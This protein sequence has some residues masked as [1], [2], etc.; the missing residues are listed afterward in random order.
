[1]KFCFLYA[2]VPTCLLLFYVKTTT[3][4]LRNRMN[5]K[6]ILVRCQAETN[7]VSR[8]LGQALCI[9]GWPCVR[10]CREIRGASGDCTQLVIAMATKG[11]IT[12][13][14]FQTALS[15]VNCRQSQKMKDEKFIFSLLL[16]LS[17]VLKVAHP[18]PEFILDAFSFFLWFVVWFM[19]PPAWWVRVWIELAQSGSLGGGGWSPPVS[20]IG[21]A[22][23][24]AVCPWSGHPGAGTSLVCW[25]GSTTLSLYCWEGTYTE[26]EK[27]SCQAVCGVRAVSINKWWLSNLIFV[28]VFLLLL[29]L[30]FLWSIT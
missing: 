30:F 9:L 16:L 17:L 12:Q 21:K 28:K 24:M 4:I 10:F 22:G 25:R 29:L 1:M 19:D 26:I 6:D 3:N 15:G 8:S 13:A 18:F 27:L 2:K 14:S 23:R 5:F 11:P 7:L 20:H